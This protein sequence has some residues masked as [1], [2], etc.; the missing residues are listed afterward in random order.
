MNVRRVDPVGP[1]IYQQKVER[2]AIQFNN[3]YIQIDVFVLLNSVWYISTWLKYFI[4]LFI[5]NITGLL[6]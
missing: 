4:H 3:S 5:K 1:W 6:D 2:T